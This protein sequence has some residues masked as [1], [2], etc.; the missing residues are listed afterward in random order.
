MSS[1][2]QQLGYAS[3]A[4]VLRFYPTPNRIALEPIL[5]KGSSAIS[6]VN[7]TWLLNYRWCLIGT[8]TGEGKILDMSREVGIIAGFI[9]LRMG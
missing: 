6:V 9:D 3:L 5:R 7:D 2:S 8:L 1:V 4:L